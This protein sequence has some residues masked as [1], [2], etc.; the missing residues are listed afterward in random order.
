MNDERAR[1]YLGRKKPPPLKKLP[2]T[3]VNMQLH[4]LRAHLQMLLWK[5]ADQ[6]DTLE[7]TH[8]IANFGWSIEG[9]T[10]TPALSTAPVAPQVLLDV[11]AAVVPQRERHATAHAAAAKA[12]D[13]H[14]RTTGSARK[15][16]LTVVF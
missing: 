12:Q 6:R 10:I 11:V 3:D 14:A 13:F 8:D 16:P 1:F 5:A 15:E 4:A 2:L 9:S 7:E